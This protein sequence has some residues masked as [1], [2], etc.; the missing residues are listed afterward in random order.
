MKASY[1][2]TFLKKPAKIKQRIMPRRIMLEAMV[3]TVFIVSLSICPNPQITM[4]T[5]VQS[6]TSVASKT[7]CKI[8]MR[9]QSE[10]MMIPARVATAVARRIGMKTSVG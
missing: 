6:P 7:G 5:K 2:F 10:V 1:T 4:P 9:C 3:V 8:L